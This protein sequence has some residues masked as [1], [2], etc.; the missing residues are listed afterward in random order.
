MSPRLSPRET[1]CLRHMA[2]GASDD[3]IAQ[4]MAIQKCT[5]RFHLNNVF[6]KLASRNR[7]AAIYRAAK[8]DI[9]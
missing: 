3:A 2:M 9:I 5:V 4:A 1:E 6:R 7:C 8:L